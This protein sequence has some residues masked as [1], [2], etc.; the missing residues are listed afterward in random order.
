MENGVS[1]KA[2]DY[3]EFVRRVLNN[4]KEDWGA[5]IRLSNNAIK[6]RINTEETDLVGC[7]V[8]LD[9]MYSHLYSTVSSLQASLDNL[10][11]PK[12]IIA[13]VAKLG[14]GYHNALR[15]ISDLVTQMECMNNVIKAQEGTIR[16]YEVKSSVSCSPP[17]NY[18]QEFNP[19]NPPYTEGCETK[20]LFEVSLS[21][22]ALVEASDYMEAAKKAIG[23]DTLYTVFNNDCI[24]GINC[25]SKYMSY[26]KHKATT[27]AKYQEKYGVK[28]EPEDVWED[29]DDDCDED[30]FSPS[31]KAKVAAKVN[32]AD[33]KSE[34]VEPCEPDEKPEPIKRAECNRPWV[35]SEEDVGYEPAVKATSDIGSL[36]NP[37][38]KPNKR[39][40][41]SWDEDEEI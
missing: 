41:K 28:Q 39:K 5:S 7:E 35:E 37:P 22:L 9:D 20:N 30:I 23:G 18:I 10:E 6:G 13:C 15:R 36:I 1:Y 29:E 32:H 40:R 14:E 26:E 4:L 31:P 19:S 25:C 8:Y 17:M 34:A 24:V 2:K 33:Y 11:V 38:L 12:E 27:L 3:N 16:D 21:T